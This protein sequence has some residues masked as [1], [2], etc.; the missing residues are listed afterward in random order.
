M[1]VLNPQPTPLVASWS[2]MDL[3]FAR[4]IPACLGTPAI[5]TFQAAGYGAGGCGGHLARYL[6]YQPLSLT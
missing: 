6:E 5:L 3:E 2:A 4:N 1:Y